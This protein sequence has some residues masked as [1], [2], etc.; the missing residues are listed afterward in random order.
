MVTAA[1]GFPGLPGCRRTRWLIQLLGLTILTVGSF[2]LHGQGRAPAPLRSAAEVAFHVLVSAAFTADELSTEPA[3]VGLYRI[4]LAPGTV[5]PV[6]TGSLPAGVGFNYVVSGAYKL[7]AD[8]LVRVWSAGSA[9]ERGRHEDVE[10]G[11]EITLRPGQAVIFPALDVARQEGNAGQ[12]PVAY[13]AVVAS[14]PLGTIPYGMPLPPGP[15]GV[16]GKPLAYVLPPAPVTANGSLVSVQI[17]LFEAMLAPGA[18]MLTHH[19]AGTERLVVG[20]GVL[21]IS[22]LRGQV[23]VARQIRFT[24]VKEVPIAAGDEEVLTVGDF[25]GLQHGSVSAVQN[26][27]E[28]PASLLLLRVNPTSGGDA[29]QKPADAP[30]A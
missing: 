27:G 8:G 22:P 3:F 20:A 26:L 16:A 17:T 15:V 11:T 28:A 21:Q 30:E 13:L 6:P 24:H 7:R 5:Q 12:A 29:I 10:P 18:A 2:P 1:A 4:E 23:T 14:S 9:G 25:A 19:A